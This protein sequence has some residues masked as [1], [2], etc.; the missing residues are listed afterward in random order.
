MVCSLFYPWS[1]SLSTLSFPLFAL[2]AHA[3]VHW[4]CCSPPAKR[5]ILQSSRRQAC[6]FV[7]RKKGKHKKKGTHELR[8]CVNQDT[9]FLKNTPMAVHPLWWSKTRKKEQQ[10][11][12]DFFTLLPWKPLFC[13]LPSCLAFL[14]T[15]RWKVNCLSAKQIGV[16]YGKEEGED[17]AG[18]KM[19][20]GWKN[21]PT[22]A[23]WSRSR[24]SVFSRWS[25]H[26]HSAACYLISGRQIL[27]RAMSQTV[28]YLNSK[29]KTTTHK[30]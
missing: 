24:W 6:K 17:S 12:V 21:K 18:W 9:L 11:R 8:V 16:V 14:H 22:K 2:R 26:I 28:E 25:F 7:P 15:M 19:H 29:K 10:D 20:K 5:V 1:L 4:H 13:L 3:L 23:M 30:D 27:S